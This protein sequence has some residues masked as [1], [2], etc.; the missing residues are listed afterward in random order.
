MYI[1]IY[2]IEVFPVV[3][4]GCEILAEAHGLRGHEK[5]ALKGMFGP[6]RE[7]VTGGWRKLLNKE[8]NNLYQSQSQ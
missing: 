3:L 1:K 2:K 4:G 6:K 7:E 5:R 8:L